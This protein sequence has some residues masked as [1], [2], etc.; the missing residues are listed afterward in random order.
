MSVV[1]RRPEVMASGIVHGD[2]EQVDVVHGAEE[3]L[4]VVGVLLADEVEAAAA[5]LAGG[6]AQ[7]VEEGGVLDADVFGRGKGLVADEGIDDVGLG[8]FLEG[9]LGVA[10]LVE[11]GEGGEVGADGGDDVAGGAEVVAGEGALVAV[12]GADG[13]GAV[14]DEGARALEGGVAGGVLGGEVGADA[15]GDRIEVIH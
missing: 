15:V 1:R 12:D 10:G 13:V 5:E 14:A 11:V 7:A 9:V 6:L 2:Q 3:A 4:G 8:V